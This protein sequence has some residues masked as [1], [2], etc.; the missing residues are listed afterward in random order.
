[1]YLLWTTYGATNPPWTLALN[2][3][4]LQISHQSQSKYP[5]VKVVP[6][7][8][9]QRKLKYKTSRS[10][11]YYSLI[12]ASGMCCFRSQAKK[13]KRE[14]CPA[15]KWTSVNTNFL[16][17][18]I[19]QKYFLF[20]LPSTGSSYAVH[21][22]TRAIVRWLKSSLPLSRHVLVYLSFLDKGCT[23]VKMP[24]VRPS[25]SIGSIEN[26]SCWRIA[27]LPQYSTVCRRKNFA[28]WRPIAPMHYLWS[29]TR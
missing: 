3:L 8:E 25:K 2:V 5:N 17:F 7:T 20:K 14:G 19:D 15:H 21:V 27:V 23:D 16:I 13:K 6:Q 1:M 9:V 22:G 18:R 29:V 26:T 28:S 12:S 4:N 11:A 24:F 10:V